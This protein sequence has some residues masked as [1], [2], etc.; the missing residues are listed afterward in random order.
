MSKKRHKKR[1]KKLTKEQWRQIRWSNSRPVHAAT[2][3]EVFDAANVDV[4]RE[5]VFGLRRIMQGDPEQE[6]ILKGTHDR[7]MAWIERAVEVANR[8]DIVLPWE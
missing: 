3:V 2:V 6:R 5:R 7:L 8:A 4:Y 1:P